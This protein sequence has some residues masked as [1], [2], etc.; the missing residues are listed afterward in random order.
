MG[1]AASLNRALRQTQGDYVARM[2]AD[3]VSLPRRFEKQIKFL[4]KNPWVVAA[5]CQVGVINQRG[6]LTGYKS[7]PT[8]PKNC[9]QM[10]MLTVPIKH[11]TLMVGAKTIKKYFYNPRMKTA[12]DWELYFKLL[13]SGELANISEMLYF[14][15][16]YFG[17]NGFHELRKAFGLTVRARLKGIFKYGYRPGVLGVIGVIGEAIL[18][19]LLPEKWVFKIFSFLR[20]K[21]SPFPKL[22]LT[23][24]RFAPGVS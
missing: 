12:E 23:S 18:V 4:Q 15:R 11:P 5:G 8:E 19:W 22:S 14:Y 20:V 2:D 21:K 13:Q 9:Y 6:E 1:V 7:F 10:L 17:S 24:F 16:Q 3:D